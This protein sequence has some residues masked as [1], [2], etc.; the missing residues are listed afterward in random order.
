[1]LCEV[2][3][4]SSGIARDLDFIEVGCGTNVDYIWF[5]GEDIGRHTVTVLPLLGKHYIDQFLC[6]DIHFKVM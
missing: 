2:Y 3:Q 1:M 5:I 4:N 6:F